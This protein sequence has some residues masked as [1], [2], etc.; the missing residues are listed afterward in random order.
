PEVVSIHEF[1]GDMPTELIQIEALSFQNSGWLDLYGFVP[2]YDAYMAPRGFV[3]S[4]SYA[5]RVLKLLQWKNPRKRWL[6]KSPDAMRSLPD[7]FKVFPDAQLIWTHRD[8]LKAV[9]S[10]V[11]LVGTL[12]WIRSE[13][14]LSEQAIAQLTSADGLANLFNRVFDQ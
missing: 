12:F 8:P 13:R 11:S 7:V 10:A 2:T 6:L 5:K 1:G 14:R 3:P 9:A 4:M